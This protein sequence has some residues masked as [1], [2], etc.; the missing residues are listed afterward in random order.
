LQI[1]IRITVDILSIYQLIKNLH[2]LIDKWIIFRL[3]NRKKKEG[4]LSSLIKS[5][6]EKIIEDEPAF[7]DNNKI[8]LDQWFKEN[9]SVE[10]LDVMKAVMLLESIFNI[11]IYDEDIVKMK[12]INDLTEYISSKIFDD[13]QLA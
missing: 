5:K 10:D 12:N 8:N 4:C 11:E 13:I 7:S 9:S 2:L 1:K 3:K 6:I